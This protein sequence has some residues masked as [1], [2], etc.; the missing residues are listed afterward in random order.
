MTNRLFES[1]VAEFKLCRANITIDYTV[2]V[3]MNICLMSLRFV[4]HLKRTSLG[5]VKRGRH[6]RLT[7]SLAIREPVFK[8]IKVFKHLTILQASKTIISIDLYFYFCFTVQLK[9]DMTILCFWSTSLFA[10]SSAVSGHCRQHNNRVCNSTPK[11]R[12]A[13]LMTGLTYLTP[14]RWRNVVWLRR[15]MEVVPL[16]RNRKVRIC[17]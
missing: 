13:S 5:E 16:R 10:G 1:Q 7:N 11:S 2:F 9:Y 8:K 12:K 3:S 4:L 17:I 6:V 15:T 14:D